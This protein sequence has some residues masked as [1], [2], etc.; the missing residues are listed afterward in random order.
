MRF[1][2]QNFIYICSFPPAQNF[3]GLIIVTEII[4]KEHH[5][6]AHI[7]IFVTFHIH[8]KKNKKKFFVY[9]TGPPL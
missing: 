8:I 3:R 6:G 4:G 5:I 9:L 2:N 1:L 7:K